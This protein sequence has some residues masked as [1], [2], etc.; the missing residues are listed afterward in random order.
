MATVLY[1]VLFLR[2]SGTGKTSTARVLAG[3]AS[4][5]LVYVPLESLVSKWYGE[6]EQNMAKVSLAVHSITPLLCSCVLLLCWCAPCSVTR[7]SC[8]TFSEQ[9]LFSFSVCTVSWW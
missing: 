3:R 2:V 9:G 5:P 6:S 1:C 8:L 4:L 7:I